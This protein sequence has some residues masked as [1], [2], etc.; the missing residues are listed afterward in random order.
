MMSRSNLKPGD[1][2]CLEDF[3]AEMIVDRISLSD[4][5]GPAYVHSS[6]GTL[7]NTELGFVLEVVSAPRGVDDS[8]EDQYARLLTSTTI[9][10]VYTDYIEKIA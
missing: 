6:V 8:G 4:V 7:K 5:P 3:T 1:L 9:G 2:V 10:W